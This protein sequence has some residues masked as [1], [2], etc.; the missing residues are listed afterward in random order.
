MNCN[1]YT[2][3]ELKKIFQKSKLPLHKA[4]ADFFVGKKLSTVLNRSFIE[5]EQSSKEC[6]GALLHSL[7]VKPQKAA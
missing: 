7:K 1:S 4:I 5:A 3:E 6:E 2:E